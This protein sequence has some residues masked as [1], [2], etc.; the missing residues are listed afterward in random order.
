MHY[1]LYRDGVNTHEYALTPALVSGNTFGKLFSCTVDGAIYA[2]PLWMPQITIGGVKHNVIFVA[3]EHDGLFAFDADR[4]TSPCTPLWS[5]NLIDA[6]HG[7]TSGETTVPS[8]GPD[9]LVGVGYGDIAPEVGVTGT[10]VIDP[11]TQTLYVVSKSVDSTQTNFYQRLHAIDLTTGSE[12]FSGP[13][14]I[15]ATYPGTYG[16][17]STTTFNA[18]QE[19][20]R[21]GL[22]LVN[23]TVYIAWASHEDD[24]PFCGWV[25]GYDA[26]TLT[27]KYALNITP[28]TGQG[29]IWMGGSAPAVDANGNLYLSSGDGGFDATSSAAP[30]NDYGDSVLQMDQALNVKQYFTPSDEENDYTE[31]LD[32]GSGGPT[33]I[34]LPASGSNP[35]HLLVVGGKDGTY[36]IINRDVMGGLGNANAW[37]LLYLTTGIFSTPAYWNNTL[38]VTSD[39]Q[40]IQAYPM[41]LQTAKIAMSPSSST[42][43]TFGFPG[44]TPVISSMPDGSN[45]ILWAIDVSNYC[46]PRSHSC[47]PAV[48][49]AY[50]AGN[51]ANELWNSSTSPANTAG[52]PVKF[53]Q[54]TIANGHVYIGTRGNN[55]GGA[56]NSTSI[57][58]ELDVY[59]ILSPGSS[60]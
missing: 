13:V 44:T 29:G 49:H 21:V 1:D 51:L 45:G 7:G 2:Q 16:G 14:T 15:A 40:G 25:M 6:A 19:L 3:T 31:D 18:R 37:Q 20:Q 58:G 41:N 43:M 9:E 4:N 56:D 23:G 39:R 27:Q 53:T 32:L 17:G 12:R 46:T 26:S 28:N 34:D 8:Y 5:V 36:Y 33:L 11:T 50:S 24:K 35:S 38:Y 52:Y 42:S 30:N 47:G 22:T 57:P 10:P 54:P 48:L 60:P 55:I 59:G